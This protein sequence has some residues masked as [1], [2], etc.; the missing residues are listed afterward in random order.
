MATWR[1]TLADNSE[2]MCSSCFANTKYV[3]IECRM[4]ICN[5]CSIFENNEDTVGWTAGT[6]VGHCEPCFKAKK[7]LE[8]NCDGGKRR[9]ANNGRDKT[10]NP[11]KYVWN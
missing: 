2:D 10:N 7:L 8:E 3:C 11:E 5:K 6:S 4:P 9:M 1:A